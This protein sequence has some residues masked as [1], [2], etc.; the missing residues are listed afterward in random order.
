M[1]VPLP[2]PAQLFWSVTVYDARTRSQ[3]QAAQ[4]KAVLSS[5]FDFKDLGGASSVDLFLGPTEPDSSG[6]RWL[7]TLSGAGWFV[8]FRNY[9]PGEQAFD[10]SWSLA[11]FTPTAWP[12][13]RR[14]L[15]APGRAACQEFVPDFVPTTSTFPGWSAWSRRPRKNDCRAAALSSHLSYWR[16]GCH[17]AREL[18]TK[19]SVDEGCATVVVTSLP[20][21][22][23]LTLYGTGWPPRV[24]ERTAPL[25]G[26]T[27]PIVR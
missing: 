21:S 9:G 5:L 24:T 17:Y 2:V 7:Q 18:T 8:Y 15:V 13:G 23:A 22:I 12:P 10:G 4:C 27:V 11:D 26:S 3:V 6:G 25:A 20:R 1:S 19:V 14:R 16:S